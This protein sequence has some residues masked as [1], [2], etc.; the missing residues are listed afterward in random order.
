MQLEL[1][2]VTRAHHCAAATHFRGHYADVNAES[3]Q[4]NVCSSLGAGGASSLAV[5]WEHAERVLRRGWRNCGDG[6]RA[7]VLAMRSSSEHPTPGP[8]DRLAHEYV[9]KDE[10]DRPSAERPISGENADR[11][12]HAFSTTKAT[13]MGRVICRS[14]IAAHGG[15][16]VPNASHG[17]TFRFTPP[18]HR[19][20]AW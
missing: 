14:I 11:A 20:T 2:A 7:A 13:G 5:L 18:S 16:A 9:F 15:W 1:I 12:F 8:V 17:A 3:R 19:E 6:N 10:L 4:M